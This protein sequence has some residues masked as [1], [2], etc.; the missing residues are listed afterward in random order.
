MNYKEI[1]DIINKLKENN[2]NDKKEEKENKTIFSSLHDLLF[3]DEDIAHNKTENN[4]ENF[5]NNS[6]K[7]LINIGDEKVDS[8]LEK[9]FEEKRKQTMAKE[10]EEYKDDIYNEVVK[11]LN[12]ELGNKKFNHAIAK[13]SKNWVYTQ[14]TQDY[15][16]EGHGHKTKFN[17]NKP[18]KWHGDCN[19]FAM[20]YIKQCMNNEVDIT[21][22][23]NK[24]LNN[25]LKYRNREGAAGIVR[26]AEHLNRDNPNGKLLVGREVNA[27]NLKEGDIIYYGSPNS[28]G[29]MN[30]RY[31][32]V[33]HIV[34]VNK[35]EKGE[36]VVQEFSG[37]RDDFKET[38]LEVWLAKHQ[39]RNNYRNEDMQL[40]AT[41]LFPDSE[42]KKEEIIKQE[43]AKRLEEKKEEMLANKQLNNQEEIYDNVYEKIKRDNNILKN[44]DV[45]IKNSEDDFKFKV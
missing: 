11:D 32:N 3:S 44:E 17:I 18:Q 36:L 38:K 2:L 31:K 14:G 1:H 41:S 45:V 13:Y 9:D 20:E 16:Q 33:S 42:M 4:N 6:T 30:G 12:L 19:D 27:E 21:G 40:H 35:N 39:K 28:E 15:I 7:L 26:Y 24:D 25:F 5:L 10:L 37:K 23:T 22:L 29:K 34:V 8:K 43:V